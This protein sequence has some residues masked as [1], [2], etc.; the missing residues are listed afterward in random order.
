MGRRAFYF[1]GEFEF[2][3]NLVQS[4][5]HQIVHQITIFWESKMFQ[6]GTPEEQTLYCFTIY[7]TKLVN[8]KTQT[9]GQGTAM[10]PF[11]S[12]HSN[13]SSSLKAGARH[14]TD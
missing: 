4:I 8:N 6:M 13:F 10:H 2:Q 12:K 3:S 1:F 5:V 11:L 7:D 9:E 14:L